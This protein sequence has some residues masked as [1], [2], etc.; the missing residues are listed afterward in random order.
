MQVNKIEYQVNDENEIESILIETILSN[1][2]DEKMFIDLVETY[3][4]EYNLHNTLPFIEYGK[5]ISIKLE[6]I[7]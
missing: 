2:Q 7:E 6:T 5:V 4:N 3:S 1:E